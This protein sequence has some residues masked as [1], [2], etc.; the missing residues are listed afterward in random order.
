MRTDGIDIAQDSIA[1]VFRGYRNL[2]I[3]ARGDCSNGSEV[4]RSRHDKAIGIIG[5]LADQVHTA[6]CDKQ[7][8]FLPKSFLVDFSGTGYILHGTSSTKVIKISSYDTRVTRSSTDQRSL[9]PGAIDRAL[10]SFAAIAKESP[11][12]EQG[13]RATHCCRLDLFSGQ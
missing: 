12:A 6:W 7:N 3:L 5:V 1:E 2:S 4:N 9:L 8:R 11:S 10:S 13:S